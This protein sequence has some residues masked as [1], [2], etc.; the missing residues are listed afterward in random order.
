MSTEDNALVTN[1]KTYTCHIFNADG[2][3]YNTETIRTLCGMVL[4][5]DTPN[6]KGNVDLLGHDTGLMC[7]NCVRVENSYEH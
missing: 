7:G 3:R 6:R 2:L 1:T 5:C 4:I